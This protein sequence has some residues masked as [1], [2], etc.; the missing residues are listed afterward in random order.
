MAKTVASRKAKGRNFQNKV[1]HQIRI[2]TGLSEDDVRPVAASVNGMDI[3]LSEAGKIVF[4]FAVECK[5]TETL[6]IWK[7]LEQAKSNASG[8]LVPLLV[9]SRNNSDTYVALKFDDFMEIINN[10]KGYMD[11][12]NLHE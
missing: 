1:A 3:Q 9:F 12:N 6:A 8:G 7:A 10:P 5:K 2:E 4:P 11:D